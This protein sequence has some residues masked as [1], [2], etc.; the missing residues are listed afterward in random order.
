MNYRILGIT[1]IV[2]SVVILS[3]VSYRNSLKSRE[4]IVFSP[5]TMLASLWNDYKREYMEAEGRTVDKQRNSVT[6]SEGQSY[7]M[8]RAVW[9]DDKETFD[10]VWDWTKEN[11]QHEND[12]LFSWLYGEDEDGNMGILI[13][14]GGQNSASDA[15]TD[16][17]HALLFAY[18]RW[19]D[20]EYLEEALPIINDIWDREVVMIRGRPY[21]AA[22]DL[23]KT[24]SP[25]SIVINPS[26]FSPYAYWVFGYFDDQHNWDALI[27]TSYEVIQQSMREG[28]DRDRSAMIPPDW[29]LMN[30]R[31]GRIMPANTGTLTTNYSYDAMRIPFRIALDYIWNNEPRAKETLAMMDFFQK[32]WMNNEVIYANY[33][34]DGSVYSTYEAPGHYGAIVAYFDIVDSESADSLYEKKLKVLYSPD[35]NGW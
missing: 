13:S 17:A 21:L 18:S 7:A 15:D 11:L 10:I 4:P 1:L 16:I 6:T 22:N 14:Q 8:L 23:E 3:F 20:P 31:T 5:K 29:I 34:H 33:A 35:E 2:A 26:Y 19:R 12:A 27:S 24:R 9:L 28:L 32:E 30:R 25:E